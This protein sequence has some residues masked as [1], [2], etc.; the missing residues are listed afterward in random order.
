MALLVLSAL[1]AS[2]AIVG[3]YD[4][5]LG[6]GSPTQVA[7]I[8]TA[9]HTPLKIF[10]LSAMELSGIDVLFVQNPVNGVYGAEYLSRLSTVNNAVDDGLVLVIHDR[11]VTDAKMILPGGGAFTAVRNF[12]NP[13]RNDVEVRDATT[14]VTNGM[15]DTITNATLDGGNFSCHGY[16]KDNAYLPAGA[17]KILTRG[18]PGEAATAATQL[19]TFSYVFG[20]GR[21]IYSTIPLDIFLA[22]G[23]SNASFATVY[24][25]NVVQYAAV[26]AIK[27]P[28]LE[29]TLTDGRSVS[30]PGESV[31]YTLRVLNKGNGD[32][33]GATVIDAFPA[34]ISGVTWSCVAAGTA[35]CT[36]SGSGNV[37]DTVNVPAGDSVTYTATGTVASASTG[38]LVNTASVAHP[39]D[40]FPAN[41]MASDTDTLAPEADLGLVKS[42]PASAVSGAMVTYTLTLT[43]HGPSDAV[44]VKLNDPTPSG[45]TIDSAGAPCAGGFPCTMATLAAGASAVVTVTFNVPSPYLG[46][47][48][49]RN[50]ATASSSTPDP[51]GSNN[52]A[53]A[54]TAVDREASA[55][56]GVAAAGPPSAAVGSLVTYR[57]D[58]TNNGTDDA[59]AVVLS[60]PPPPGL[61]FNSAKPPC[62]GGLPCNLGSLGAGATRRV[63][64]TFGIPGSYAGA[65]PI[66][67]N[68]SVASTTADPN[69]ANNTAGAG[70][71]LG[72]DTADL[73]VTKTGPA[74]GGLD[75]D[76][77]YLIVVTNN[78]PADATGVTLTDATPAG[79][80]FVAAT[81]PCAAGFPCVLGGLAA[82]AGVEVE[83]TFRVPAGYTGADPVVNE[84][85]VSASQTEGYLPDNASRAFTGLAGELADVSIAKSGP[86]SVAAGSTLTYTLLVRNLGP[87]VAHDVTV[88]ETSPGALVF[89]EASAPCAGGFPCDLGDLG[90]GAAV[91]IG[92]DF[93]VASNHVAPDPIDNQATVS[94][95]NVDPDAANNTDTAS[96]D[97]V[98]QADLAVTKDD[99]RTSVSPSLPV[100]Y[101]ITVTN[102]G[103]SDAAGVTVTDTFPAQ[104]TG[105]SWT[106]SGAGGASCT[107]GG[108]GNVSDVVGLPA[109]ASVTYAANATVAA[110]ASGTLSNTASAALPAG[111]TDPVAANDSAT[112]EDEILAPVD[113]R[114][115]KSGPATA[116]P[117][118][119]V[120]YTLQVT[121]DGPGTAFD[122][123]L[124]DPTP[125]GLVFVSATPPCAG[126]FPCVLP[127]L[128]AAGTA[129]VTVTYQVPAGYSGPAAISNTATVSTSVHDTDSANDS[130]TETTAVQPTAD[131]SVVKNDGRDNLVPGEDVTYTIVVRNFGPSAVT[132]ATV[133]DNPPALLPSPSWTCTP[134]AGASCTASGSGAINQTVDLAV[135]ATLTYLLTATVAPDA[136][137]AVINEVTVA[138]PAGY[139]DPVAG[140]DLASDSSGLTPS[141]DLV[142]T[143]DNGLDEVVAGQDLTYTVTVTNLGPSDVNGVTVTDLFPA[144]LTGIGWTCAEAGG[145]GC[146]AASGSGDL[147]ETVDLPAGAG[148]T[149]TIDA[150]VLSSATGLLSNTATA[151]LPPGASDP[152]ALSLATD[153]DPL[154]RVAD[155]ALA[156]VGPA[157]I[158]RGQLLAYSL[159]LRNDGPSDAAVTLTDPTPAGLTFV[160]AGAPC[161][162]GFP[163]DVDPLAAGSDLVMTVTYQVPADYDGP[164]PIVNVAAVS[165][166]AVDP[167][168]ADNKASSATPVERPGVADVEAIKAAPAVSSVGST[169]TYVL[170]AVNHG[171]DD[172]QGV[173]L[174]ET[175]PAGFTFVSAT[176]PCAGGFDCTLGT[177]PV[178]ARVEVEVTFDIPAG[179]SGPTIVVN[180]ASVT[181][182]TADPDSV[183][184][185]VNASTTLVDDPVDLVLSKLGPL[186]VAPGDD[187]VATLEVTQRGPGTATNVILDDPTPPGLV[188]VAAGS[189]CAAGF[190][191]FLD[192]VAPG[193][194][195]TVTVTF[196]VPAAYAG[197]DPIVNV[198]GVDANELDAEEHDNTARLLTGVGAE[199]ADV[200]MMKIGPATVAAGAD[201]TYTLAVRNLGP[202]TA[203][204]VVLTDPAPAGTQLVAASAPC[205]AGLPCNL[206]DLPPGSAVAV[207]ATYRLASGLAAGSVITN[208]AGVATASSDVDPA[209]DSASVS[210]TSTVAADL[211]ITKTDGV[212]AIAPGSSV[213]YV[214]TVTNLG[215]SNAPGAT[216]TDTFPAVI[217]GVSW[218]CAASA[219]S[220]CGGVAAGSG[221]LNRTVNLLAGGTVTFTATGTIDP[222]VSGSLSNTAVVTPPAAVPDPNPANNSATDVDT[223]T[224]RADLRI[225]KVSGGGGTVVPGG[226]VTYTIRVTNDGPT[227][228]LGATVTDNF[229]ASLTNVSWTCAP[230]AGS[231]C[232][233]AGS[234]RILD[235]VDLLVGGTA[236]YTVTATVDSALTANLVNTATVEPPDGFTDPNLA[237]NSATDTATPAPQADLEVD[238]DDGLTDAVP[239]TQVTYEVTVTN[240][241]PSDVTGATVHD[242]FP[243]A[244]TA[245]A[246]TC[247]GTGAATCGAAGSDTLTDTA[248]IPA[249][250]SV[251][252]LVT[253]DVDPAATGN[254]LNAADVTSP[255][256]IPDPDTDDNSDTDSDLLTP[257]ADLGITKTD[258][259]TE[260]VPGTQVTYTVTVTNAGP[261]N[262]TGATVSDLL[263]AQLTAASWTCAGTGGAS[264]TAAGAGHVND[265]VNVPAGAGVTYT[266]KATIV[267]GATGNLVNTATVTKPASV[268]DPN[269]ANDSASD[270][271]VLVVSR[272]FSD[273]FESGD[274]SAWSSVVGP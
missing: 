96:T 160:S 197:P 141:A 22:G 221:N 164:D 264:C 88:T 235:G 169:V 185:T 259:Q 227:N 109:G 215:P 248:D 138:V 122:V 244:V 242:V 70:V 76:L 105:V 245:V 7:P 194:T 163:C 236:T 6:Q 265:T 232:T 159:T 119:N 240:A 200:E 147:S 115:V 3:Y 129:S 69:S 258:G 271:D 178:G 10:D 137:V 182:T 27:A 135:G 34:K 170:A 4:M 26:L 216:V 144:A 250:E 53:A 33:V 114:V 17:V 251:T 192:T 223:L 127:N 43:N 166:D 172:A 266:L 167:D 123:T 54:A 157:R 255:A 268:T 218:T 190:P 2:A 107:A 126:G 177:I 237:N 273:G 58:V 155:L 104:L 225:T 45:L 201:A 130:D 206:G 21:V 153:E 202:G 49:I 152:D 139:V 23:G 19:V 151:T 118:T 50:L 238:K 274:T 195:V 154:V 181:S 90:P 52:V 75:Q 247:S 14:Q 256:G 102:N 260:A 150:T 198:A 35:S 269:G 230:S 106:C 249:G 140:N 208:T 71:P 214:V 158:D 56:L 161:A 133:T 125:A 254:L 228:A 85:S 184:D 97:V 41:D 187:L 39:A 180:T 146:G 81:S 243:A 63:E 173:V 18:D 87:G 29:V 168:P 191:C 179:Y 28:D 100:T 64:V 40:P 66:V 25:P 20:E 241:G 95:A 30:V 83:A 65:N 38:T 253:V 272:I 15:A 262:V 72:A 224:P 82:G 91:V 267:P 84:A 210:T 124:A 134:S 239:G 5:F 47:D 31:T 98:F 92:A 143:K 171:P 156:K 131:L 252:Y 193:E 121:N 24:A 257:V 219:G 111:I 212:T 108:S 61:L 211:A 103:P 209:N 101:T 16:V 32:A 226:Q 204:A 120:V 37:N 11:W 9:G 1:P 79:L 89:Q 68:A 213:T 78:G 189:P 145:A 220:S 165:S 86:A 77:T 176:A 93:A 73:Q 62:Q 229:P 80:T 142:V 270:T 12:D 128:A 57:I 149:F 207:T 263:P 261:S 231:S 51:V 110:A 48:P 74:A 116:V 8:M 175:I 183:N 222:G 233:A 162:G 217:S 132:G 94:S 67:Y 36:A 136:Q 13:E 246:W 60:G 234:V 59:S 188:F 148:V 112:D 117:G 46:P 199:A 42:G 55:D 99:G 174:K 186:S 203:A 205:A 196:H 113:L 44:G